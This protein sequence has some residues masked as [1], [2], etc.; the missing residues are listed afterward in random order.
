[1]R[2]TVQEQGKFSPKRL[3]GLVSILAI[4]ALLASG[5]FAWLDY[6]QHKTND[7]SGDGTKYDVTLNEDFEEVNN[8]KL[9]APD[10]NKDITVT[11]TGFTDG[12]YGDVFVRLQLKEYFDLT[13]VVYNYSMERYMVAAPDA[14]DPKKSAFVEE[15]NALVGSPVAKWGPGVG[16]RNFVTFDTPEDA[17]DFLNALKTQSRWKDTYGTK[18]RT[19]S[20][21]IIAFD[22]FVRDENGA[23]VLTAGQPT[24]VTRYYIETEADDPN[25]QYG[26]YLPLSVTTDGAPEVLT[27][28][29]GFTT[30][31]SAATDADTNH[32]DGTANCLQWQKDTA[33]TEPTPGDTVRNHTNGECDYLVHL[34]DEDGKGLPS[35]DLASHKYISWLLGPDVETL[36]NWRANGS[37]PVAK[38]IVDTDSAEG[39]A[40][41]GQPL[42]PGE[43]TSK[44][45]DQVSLIKQPAGKF[46]YSIHTDMEAVSIE[47]MWTAS[48]LG[49]IPTGNKAPVDLVNAITGYVSKIDSVSVVVDPTSV[50]VGGTAQA[51]AEVQGPATNHD[52]T[53]SI[54]PTTG[55]ST[56][57]AT[58]GIVTVSATETATALVVTGKSVVDPTKQASSTLTVTH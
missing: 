5:T 20:D 55:G 10:V 27:T 51:Y 58:T 7:F 56:I 26:R 12:T 44:L 15:I 37:K 34:W 24:P 40:Y 38:W 22:D 8:W 47:D 14:T 13:P 41:W 4:V 29:T 2:R 25:G 49:E 39:W 1:M 43:T 16:Y 3:T 23:L 36:A 30:P 32:D 50:A 48:P 33:N 45:L 11:N 42:K 57:D 54:A 46:N 6:D 35:C 53:W 19:V 28:R 18:T 31:T 52:V 17:A 9:N 21:G